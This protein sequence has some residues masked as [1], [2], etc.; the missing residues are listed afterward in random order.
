MAASPPA[1]SDPWLWHSLTTCWVVPR[2]G[3]LSCCSSR[4]LRS[5]PDGSPADRAG[6]ALRP[7]PY[8]RST[9]LC[10]IVSTLVIFLYLLAMPSC[11]SPP[12]RPSVLSL[13]KLYGGP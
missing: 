10:L 7:E 8:T 9:H 13:R 11:P 2:R 12:R 1:S 3:C 6:R 4:L 5:E